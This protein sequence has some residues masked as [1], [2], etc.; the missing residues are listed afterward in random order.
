MPRKGR[1]AKDG[2]LSESSGEGR[3]AQGMTFEGRSERVSRTHTWRRSI[4]GPESGTCTGGAGR[5]VCSPCRVHGEARL[6]T[7][8]LLMPPE[9]WLTEDRSNRK[10]A[11][12]L[13]KK[14]TR[15][16]IKIFHKPNK[17]RST[18]LGIRKK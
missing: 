9:P 5:P 8:L 1:E 2:E 13:T 11:R 10:A 12:I 16:E 4:P 17:R 15:V 14:F 3:L 7:Q 6:P 18:S